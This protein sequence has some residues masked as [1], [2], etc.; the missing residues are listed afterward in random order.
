MS[1]FDDMLKDSES[2]FLNPEQ[3]D[4]DFQPKLVPYRESEQKYIASCIKPLFQ[5]RNGKNLLIFGKPGVGKTVCLKHVLNELEEYDEIS[6]IYL[7][8]WKKDTAH[9][10]ALSIC[11]QIDY[12]WTHNKT[13]DELFKEI[14]NILNKKTVVFVLDESDKLTEMN[15]V[16]YILED[17]YKKTIF[18]ITNNKDWLVNVD[19]RLKSRLTLEELEFKYYTLEQTRGILK[20][21][22]EYAFVKNVWDDNSFNLIANKTFELKDVRLGLFLLR[23]TGNIAED[24]SSKKIVL[25]HSENA[26]KRLDNYKMKN[27]EDFEDDINKVLELIK[28]NSGK[29]MTEIYDIYKK[30]NDLSYRTF[31]RKVSKLINNNVITAEDTISDKGGKTF[32]LNYGS[33]K[34][35]DE[36]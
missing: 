32:I 13:T 22:I 19:S 26:I 25:D 20:K 24:N 11:E 34:K 8:C 31:K 29:T 14:T 28:V 30:D 4:F 33:I 7:N 3:L 17:I 21:R 15:G 2:L 35:L 27:S 18:F 10:M 36:F 23:E 6:T 1:L 16:Y 5:N 9:K 12:K